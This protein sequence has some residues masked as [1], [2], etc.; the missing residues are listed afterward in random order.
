LQ[1]AGTV[2]VAEVV[3]A[4]GEERPRETKALTPPSEETE[5]N[6]Y[7]EMVDAFHSGKKDD[8]KKIFEQHIVTVLDP[9]AQLGD[10]AFYL[11]WAYSMDSDK[12]ALK[13]LQ[14]LFEQVGNQEQRE[15]VGYWL[16]SSYRESKNFLA[17]KHVWETLLSYEISESKQAGFVINISTCLE[18]EQKN[19]EA[20]SLVESKLKEL[21][22][23]EALC[24]LFTKL[25]SLAA[26]HG[27][28]FLAATAYE[29]ALQ[30]RPD[31]GDILFS[32]AYAQSN[33]DLHYLSYFN[34]DT[35]IRLL[36]NKDVAINNMGAG[37]SN[38]GMQGRSVQYYRR[39]VEKGN[40][41]A[42]ANMAY[43]Y[44]SKGFYEE[45][46][47]ILQ[48]GLEQKEAH[49]NVSTAFAELEKKKNEEKELEK[50]TLEKAAKQRDFLRQF[51]EARFLSDGD[52]AAFPGTWNTN[53]GTRIEL[54]RE[55]QRLFGAW[56]ELRGFLSTVKRTY[57]L[58]A[59][60]ENCSARGRFTAEAI[61]SQTILGSEP[62]KNREFVAYLTPD[63]LKFRMMFLDK[64][65][66]MFIIFTTNSPNVEEEPL[67]N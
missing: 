58:E 20:R 39:A 47:D 10:R 1:I 41:L 2:E 65:E 23:P 24:T 63:G 64:E 21:S 29:K 43:L 66:P 12:G 52:K 48:K 37:A 4:S 50:K 53:Y 57:K 11:Y 34:Y 25:G 36:P 59:N 40:T 13:E 44:I 16:A 33:T 7:V 19:E 54:S 60:I 46:R 61:K 31:D 55:G 62:A 38:L 22:D 27:N 14:Q 51:T 56:E 32:A 17:E 5:K 9:V 15:I 18:E 28:K 8:A 45:A 26:E 3:E 35:L 42:M 6:W 67:E 49:Q 30:Y